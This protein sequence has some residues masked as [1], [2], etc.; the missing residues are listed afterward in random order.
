MHH[1]LI[2]SSITHKHSN[3]THNI[4]VYANFRPP[5][6]NSWA[7]PWTYVHPQHKGQISVIFKPGTWFLKLF[8]WCVC[9]LCACVCV[10]M[11][12]CTW[13]CACICVCMCACMCVYMRTHV[14][15]R[16]SVCFP[17]L[18]NYSPKIKPEL[19]VKQV[20]LIW[21]S[22]SVLLMGGALVMSMLWI[23]AKR[24]KVMLY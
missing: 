10:H 21:H 5:L 2:Y 14:C 24:L 19:L 15:V 17:R 23:T 13:V 9:V 6:R 1:N 20:V 11:R 8:N 12:V 3:T 16:P 22:P 7:E 18:L 4:S